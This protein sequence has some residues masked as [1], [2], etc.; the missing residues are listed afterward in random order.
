MSK[1]YFFL[2]HWKINVSGKWTFQNF[3]TW[4]K[5][6]KDWLI[7]FVRKW[8]VV[9]GMILIFFQN[10][11]FSNLKTLIFKRFRK[12]YFFEKKIFFDFFSDFS[13]KHIFSDFFLRNFH[14]KKSKISFFW[15]IEKSRKLFFL[16]WIFFFGSRCRILRFFGSDYPC[17]YPSVFSFF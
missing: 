13:Q 17:I 7:N 11:K 14:E 4:K 1:K 8:R 2:K 6:S 16:R 9:L 3:E 5:N 12:S 10:Q 15:N